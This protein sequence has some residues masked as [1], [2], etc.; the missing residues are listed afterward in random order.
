MAE[1]L[2]I[3]L[4]KATGR[5]NQNTNKLLIN[6]FF[7]RMYEYSDEFVNIDDLY[8]IDKE[9]LKKY[10]TD[11]LEFFA[12]KTSLTGLKYLVKNLGLWDDILWDFIHDDQERIRNNYVLTILEHKNARMSLEENIPL[13]NF[14]N[15]LFKLMFENKHFDGSIL[16]KVVNVTYNN[17]SETNQLNLLYLISPGKKYMPDI[18]MKLLKDNVLTP[19]NTIEPL[20]KIFKS[21]G[22]GAT[23]NV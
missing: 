14:P 12:N 15:D 23:Y 2:L 6:L 21:K 11:F 9:I 3:A 19:S 22:I 4:A 13:N 20:H 17:P 16:E 1:D 10:K 5:K 18:A 8:K 7:N